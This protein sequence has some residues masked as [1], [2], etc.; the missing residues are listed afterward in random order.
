MEW[1]IKSRDY[2]KSITVLS[3]DHNAKESLVVCEK[4][5]YNLDAIKNYSCEMLRGAQR[6]SSCDAYREVNGVHYFIEFK[7]QDQDKIDASS[8]KKKAFDSISIMR[9][10]LDPDITLEQLCDNSILLV[11]FK[12]NATTGLP[13]IRATLHKLAN[14]DE[15]EPILFGLEKIK[16]KLYSDIHTIDEEAF[17]RD[18]CPK[19]WKDPP[20]AV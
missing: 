8:I 15:S 17:R 11:V 19:I 2:E 12:K 3:Y 6:L 7:N 4:T 16:G 13:E 10:S 18:W 14:E 9:I 5:A 1:S 20:A